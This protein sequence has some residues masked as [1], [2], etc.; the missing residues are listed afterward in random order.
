M[1]VFNILKKKKND[2][3]RYNLK[4]DNVNYSMNI[5]SF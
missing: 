2:N 5:D 4:M 1:R 3:F